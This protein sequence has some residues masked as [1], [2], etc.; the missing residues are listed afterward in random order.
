MH[1]IPRPRALYEAIA[2]SVRERI[3]AHDLEPGSNIDEVALAQGYGVS[4]T[5]VREALKVL[6]HEG[7]VEMRVHNGCTV[8]ELSPQDVIELLE[9]LELLEQHMLEHTDPAAWQPASASWPE[10]GAEH[11]QPAPL[12]SPAGSGYSP[13]IQRLDAAYQQFLLHHGNRHATEIIL[14]LR[15]KLRLALGPEHTLQ[16][17][18]VLAQHFGAGTAAQHMAFSIRTAEELQRCWRAFSQDRRRIVLQALP[19]QDLTETPSRCAA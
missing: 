14:K 18:R 4:R 10:Q 11:V 8:A 1:L 5:P 9:M 2:D 3:F 15:E 12:A 17:A 19:T 6:A 7:L 13:E 16:I